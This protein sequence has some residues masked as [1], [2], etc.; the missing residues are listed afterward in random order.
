MASLV[1]ST[2]TI[3]ALAPGATTIIANAH[4]TPTVVVAAHPPASLESDVCCKC[5]V[6]IFESAFTTRSAYLLANGCYALHNEG[7]QEGLADRLD[8]CRLKPNLSSVPLQRL[9]DTPETA[10]SLIC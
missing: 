4:T 10:E 7:K 9:P 3:I 5:I 2:L 1:P 8:R 6:I